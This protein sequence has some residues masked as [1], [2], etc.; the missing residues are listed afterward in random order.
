MALSINAIESN[1]QFLRIIFDN[2]NAAIFLV[3]QYV[4]IRHLNNAFQELFKSGKEDVLM[5]LCGNAI[6]CCYTVQEGL[7]CGQTS[8]CSTCTIR[9]GIL[10]ALAGR[11]S[12]APCLVSRQF[13]IAGK[14]ELKYL[15]INFKPIDVQNEKMAMLIV[16]DITDS[17]IARR[18]V[19]AQN[20][21]IRAM[22][23]QYRNELK[24]AQKVQRDIIPKHMPEFP[25]I[26]IDARYY[27][28][29]AIG[30]DIY[31]VIPIDEDRFGLFISDVSG[32]GLPAAMVTTML[33]AL[34][35]NEREL[36]TQPSA[37]CEYLNRKMMDLSNEMYL[38]VIYGVYNRQQ[39]HFK[40]VRCGHPPLIRISRGEVYELEDQGT[41]LLGFT[42]VLEASEN[43]IQLKSEDKLLLYTDG[44]TETWNDKKVEFADYLPQFLKENQ[45]KNVY[46][47][48]VS[49]D[50]ALLTHKGHDQ[51]HDDI[52]YVG[53]EVF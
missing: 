19:L 48:L 28:L 20:K 12:E 43:M 33:K 21:R 35:R 53:L 40:Y 15:K 13:E 18:E 45:K 36:L 42:D 29:E 31:D 49:L 10:D 41:Y 4:Q 16:D 11:A 17:E 51:F 26:R 38:S 1:A 2:I 47:L 30:G 14:M 7:D 50:E 34:V 25:E 8:H 23:D 46:D 22:N 44:L 27:P 5:Q 6:G 32:H 3:D 52:C 9:Q 37:F 24:L 39:H